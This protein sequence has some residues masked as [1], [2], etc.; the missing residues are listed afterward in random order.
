MKNL[1][2]T[3]F[4]MTI[5]AGVGAF[6]AVKY[7][8]HEDQELYDIKDK[9]V[10]RNLESQFSTIELIKDDVSRAMYAIDFLNYVSNVLNSTTVDEF[11]DEAMEFDSF[12]DR[13]RE[14]IKEL[15]DEFEDGD[16]D[17]DS[18]S[19]AVETDEEDTD[20][21]E[22][23]V[24][25]DDNEEEEDDE[26]LSEMTDIVESVSEPNEEEMEVN[27]SNESNEEE[28]NEPAGNELIS[29]E[30]DGVV[31]E[32]V[33][34]ENGVVDNTNESEVNKED[35]KNAETTAFVEL[36]DKCRDDKG[37]LDLS[38][39]KKEG[40]DVT[41]TKTAVKELFVDEMTKV[42]K[43]PNESNTENLVKYGYDL[44][45]L[46][47][48]QS[49]SKKLLDAYRQIG[50]RDMQEKFARENYNLRKMVNAAYGSICNASYHTAKKFRYIFDDMIEKIG[51][52]KQELINIENKKKGV[53]SD[54]N[55]SIQELID[56]GMV[57]GKPSYYSDEDSETVGESVA[58]PSEVV[59]EE[60]PEMNYALELIDPL[61]YKYGKRHKDK[62]TDMVY[63]LVDGDD[64]VMKKK[65]ID[66]LIQLRDKDP[67][68][69]SVILSEV[70]AKY[71]A[72]K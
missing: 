8:D 18:E 69:G 68:D 61:V 11:I 35:M 15:D 22:E 5:G 6:A 30:T 58:E 31:E 42:D 12:I 46:R 40:L 48:Y 37:D 59:Q 45:M 32:V 51:Y 63:Q 49:H 60:N 71:F 70:I 10:G 24:E 64:E 27:N 13:I 50:N 67:G 41:K 66:K 54:V 17:D 52:S 33:S 39:M 38:K 34:E 44:I 7:R 72:E 47:V 65:Y 26:V 14:T 19:D 56:S 28:I 62:L 53:K 4:I 36:L 1:F 29:I 3:M 57:Q 23:D 2:K 25:E 55:S 43:D 20:E 21:T 9:F 16:E